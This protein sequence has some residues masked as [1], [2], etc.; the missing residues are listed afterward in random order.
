MTHNRLE[1]A[2]NMKPGDFRRHYGVHIHI[3]NQMIASYANA[4]NT[5]KKLGRP[6]A[7]S[8]EEQVL[9]TLEFWREY[10]TLFHHG[11]EWGI[12]ETTALRTIQRVEDALIKSGS[13][14]LPSKRALRENVEYQVVIVDVTETPVERPKKSSDDS[15]AAKRSVTPSKAK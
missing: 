6:A 13:F 14:A 10:P 2:R 3:F 5:K 15:T 1:R 4:Q 9:F 8:L 12:H 11:F 7:L